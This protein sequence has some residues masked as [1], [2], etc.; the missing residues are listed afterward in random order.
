MVLVREIASLWINNMKTLLLIVFI[1]ISCFSRG[2]DTLYMD[3]PVI[4]IPIT[5]VDTLAP[6]SVSNTVTNI[7]KKSRKVRKHIQKQ[8]SKLDKASSIEQNIT[9]DTSSIDNEN[10]NFGFLLI[11]SLVIISV[12]FFYRFNSNNNQTDTKHNEEYSD[13]I[14]RLTLPRRST[15][16]MFT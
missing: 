8:Q 3:T 7:P 16:E 9:T 13:Y 15:T 12:A 14:K 6:D 10:S 5:T 2:Q 1:G 4:T 11:L